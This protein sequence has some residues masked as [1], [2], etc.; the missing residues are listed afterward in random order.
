MD[1]IREMAS[2][3]AQTIRLAHAKP[4]LRPHLLP[5]LKSAKMPWGGGSDVNWAE[6]AMVE[7]HRLTRRVRDLKK[8]VS[9]LQEV[10]TI[11]RSAPDASGDELLFAMSLLKAVNESIRAIHRDIKDVLGIP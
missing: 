11:I 8:A 3:R 4:E 1:V 6:I 7:R 10:T 9:T 2:L 5:L